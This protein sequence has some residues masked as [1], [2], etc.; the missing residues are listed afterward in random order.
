MERFIGIDNMGLWPNL[1]T[2]QDRSL[3]AL[4]FNQ[5]CHGTRPGE[6]EAW[7]SV[8]GGRTWQRRGVPVPHG[9]SEI[10]MNVAAGLTPDGAWLCAVWGFTGWSQVLETSLQEGRITWGEFWTKLPPN[11]ARVSRSH[12]GGYTWEIIGVLPSLA[13]YTP[14]VPYGDIHSGADGCLRM[15]A[16]ADPVQED[17]VEYLENAKFGSSFFLRSPDGGASWEIQSILPINGS[18]ETAPIYKGSGHWLAASRVLESCGGQHLSLCESHDDGTT[19]TEGEILGLRGS[20]PGAFLQMKDRLLLVHG[21]RYLNNNGIY[22]RVYDQENQGW[23]TPRQIVDLTGTEDV[24]YPS[25]ALNSDGSVVVAYYADRSPCH[26]RY[27][28]GVLILD[29]NEL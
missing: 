29:E 5:P 13:G 25:A 12:D 23:T 4:V 17:S 6:V 22:T 10:R 15:S 16:Y 27:H 26:Q 7:H 11:T 28:M 24:G 1:T 18:N 2:L 14:L 3:G 9:P 8:D 21:S 20:F 19:W